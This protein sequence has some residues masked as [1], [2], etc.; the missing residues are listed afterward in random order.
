MKTGRELLRQW[1]KR[2]P[3]ASLR[4]D[5][6]ELV[7][8]HF[9]LCD[10]CTEDPAFVEAGNT[11]KYS[12]YGKGRGELSFALLVSKRCERALSSQ[13]RELVAL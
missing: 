6:G 9:Q 7:P 12:L 10:S 5:G 1:E 13:S 4:R 3:Q 2:L 8:K 11:L